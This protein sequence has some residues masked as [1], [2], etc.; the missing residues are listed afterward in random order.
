MD[1]AIQITGWGACV[2]PVVAIIA[3]LIAF[4]ISSHVSAHSVPDAHAWLLLA[5]LWVVG[6]TA[7]LV[8]SVVNLLIWL[9]LKNL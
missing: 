7:C 2:S 6:A 3:A 1:L 4:W 9:I 5:A 8:Y